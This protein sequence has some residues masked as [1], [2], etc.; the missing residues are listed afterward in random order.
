MNVATELSP[1]LEQWILE[2]V[3]AGH[4]PEAVLGPLVEQGWDEQD[5]ID[6]IE[7]ATRRFLESHAREH[8]LPPSTRVPSPIG[9]NGPSV[10]DAGDREVHLL[11]SLR[12]PRIIVFGG[13]LS[14]GECDALVELARPKLGRS[15]T[16]DLETGGDVVHEARTSH[17]MGFE[18]DANALCRRIEARIARLV[19]WPV[20]NGEGIQILRY[21]HGAEYKPH[22]DYFDPSYPGLARL[23]ERGGQRVASLVMYLNTPAS[24]GATV[25]PE[26]GFEAA[27]VKGNAVFFS[28]DRPHPMTQTLHGGAPVV[29]GEKWIATKWLR[30]RRF[31]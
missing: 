8:G 16:V 24:G 21:G 22:H 6:A 19:E 1:G 26:V 30:E 5:A 17:G 4:P 18:R 7:E 31:D 13:L 12:Q 10:V 3:R 25:F 29:E 14:H 9:L 20:E 23:L 2:Q 27:A 28:Y 15:A 11:A